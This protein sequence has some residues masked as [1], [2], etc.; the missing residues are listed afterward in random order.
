M[1]CSPVGQTGDK[2]P[3]PVGTGESTVEERLY[4][5]HAAPGPGRA[6]H[7]APSRDAGGSR[8]DELPTGLLAP[9]SDGFSMSYHRSTTI[10]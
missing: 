7:A 10:S 5:G 3:A 8:E 4:L 6:R 9:A 1:G 2:M